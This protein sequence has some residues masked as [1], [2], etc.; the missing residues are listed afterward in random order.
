MVDYDAMERLRIQGKKSSSIVI[1]GFILFVLGVI[2]STFSGVIVQ[3]FLSFISDGDIEDGFVRL[4]AF[5]CVLIGCVL[6]VV[7]MRKKKAARRCFMR[8]YKP[9]CLVPLIKEMFEGVSYFP[10]EGFSEEIFK[11]I[12][13]IC[14]GDRYRSYDYMEGVYHGIY[15]QQAAVKTWTPDEKKRDEI[16][17]GGTWLIADFG[18]KFDYDVKIVN[19]F[20]SGEKIG[21]GYTKVDT[22]NVKFNKV[23]GVYAKDPHEAFYIVTPQVMEA[24]LWAA[25]YFR[26]NP[27]MFCFV[28]NKLHI[29]F[30]QYEGFFDPSF[31]E[32]VTEEN[33]RKQVMQGVSLFTIIIDCFCLPFYEGYF[34][35]AEVKD[36]VIS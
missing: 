25:D 16:G 35:G 10:N 17:F 1:V 23:Y 13:L 3:L 26:A 18:K 31:D 4:L 27:L 5:V 29:A 32:P 6:V 36:D 8:I 34:N 15:F 12:P 2:F 33:I 11:Q 30:S 19:H 9:S 7:G 21:T 24:C 28:D 14:L 20:F 22:E